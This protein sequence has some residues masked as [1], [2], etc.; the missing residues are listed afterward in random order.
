MHKTK[1]LGLNVTD[2]EEDKL[3]SFSFKTDLG[4]NFEAIDEETLTHRNI[5]NCLLEVPKHIKY[6]LRDGILTI[7]SGSIVA[8]PYGTEDLTA[9]YPIGA[10]F[11]N[12]NYKI[13][14]TQFADNKFF[15]LVELQNDSNILMGNSGK[16]ILFLNYNGQIVDSNYSLVFSGDTAPEAVASKRWYDTSSNY[17]KECVNIEQGFV[18]GTYLSLPLMIVTADT[19]NLIISIDNVSDGF[20]YIGSTVF[21]LPGIVGL[22][23]NGKNEDESLGNIKIK[24]KNVMLRNYADGTARHILGFNELDFNSDVSNFYIQD[25]QPLLDCWWIWLNPKTNKMY[26]YNNTNISDVTGK[27]LSALYVQVKD[28]VITNLSYKLPFH[29]VDFNDYHSKIT[30]LETKIQTLQQAIEALQG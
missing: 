23:S 26:L 12:S 17:L 9:Q 30:E 2:I 20:G 3:Q 18:T 19:S 7:K 14:K 5:T 8:I 4:D 22:T 15:V 10:D 25:T 16:R 29:A 6:D 27:T 24:T 11:L 21:A 13:T 28:G 1:H